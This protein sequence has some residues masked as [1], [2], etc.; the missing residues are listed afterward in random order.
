MH[1]QSIRGQRVGGGDSGKYAM[2]QLKASLPLALWEPAH[3]DIIVALKGRLCV[4]AI[5]METR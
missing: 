5:V 2:C 4:E 1:L 3:V